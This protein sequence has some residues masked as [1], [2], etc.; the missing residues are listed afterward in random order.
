[1]L[2][3][4]D[5]PIKRFAQR[6]TYHSIDAIADNDLGFAKTR[7][8][9]STNSSGFNLTPSIPPP[10]GVNPLVAANA[11]TNGNA[12]ANDAGNTSAQNPNKRPPPPAD[13]K[14]TEYKRPRPDERERDRSPLQHQRERPGQ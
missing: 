7:K 9:G 8:L 1:M 5:A 11:N 2:D 14:P 6:H 10:G 13:R 3:S 12:H 4:L